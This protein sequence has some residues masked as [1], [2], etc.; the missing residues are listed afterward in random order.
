VSGHRPDYAADFSLQ[1]TRDL[2]DDAQEPTP[3]GIAADPHQSMPPGRQGPT[4]AKR[5][6]RFLN[7][8]DAALPNVIPITSVYDHAA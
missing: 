7:Q 3:A 6:I 2:V 8:S 4:G 1:P 5:P